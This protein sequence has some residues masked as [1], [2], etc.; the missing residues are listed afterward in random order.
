MA[1]GQSFPEKPAA[2]FGK[3]T[4]EQ[5]AYSPDGKLLAVAGG[6][7]VWLYDAGNLNEAWLL[8][9]PT[10]GVT[11]VVFSPDGKLLASSGG[12]LRLWDVKKP[13]QVAMLE[14]HTGLVSSV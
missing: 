3:G 13:K 9:G 1:L 5:I 10:S 6:L 8:E 2:R 11:S 7:G 14:G 12:D 4:V